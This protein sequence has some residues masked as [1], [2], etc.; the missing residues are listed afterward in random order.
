[1]QESKTTDAWN[2]V[3]S[4]VNH[5][6]DQNLL[7]ADCFS[8]LGGLISKK[9]P[10]MLLSP[11]ICLLYIKAEDNQIHL[12]FLCPYFIFDLKTSFHWRKGKKRK[13]N[14]NTKTKAR[15]KG[16]KRTKTLNFQCLY[17]GKFWNRL[18]EFFALHGY[19]NKGQMIM[20][21]SHFVVWNL[22]VK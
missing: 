5:R 8:F 17:S 11:L 12:F 16:A 20:F 14:G 4:R 18:S 2:F 13:Y 3:Y 7:F 1:M 10:R 6:L 22:E 9:C 19:L 15:N 21:F